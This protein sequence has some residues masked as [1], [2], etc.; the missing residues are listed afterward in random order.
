MN[1]RICDD[2]QEPCYECCNTVWDEVMQQSSGVYPI[3]VKSIKNDLLLEYCE[4]SLLY[5]TLHML[6]D[7]SDPR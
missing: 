1:Y 7:L 6:F 5:D 4:W 2:E 3:Q